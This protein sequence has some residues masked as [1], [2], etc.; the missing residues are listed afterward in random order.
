MDSGT[1][2]LDDSKVRILGMEDDSRVW[3]KGMKRRMEDA[4]FVLGGDTFISRDS[5]LL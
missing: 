4:D 5:Q 2:K 3:I 1:H